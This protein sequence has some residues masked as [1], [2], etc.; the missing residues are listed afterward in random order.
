[1]PC[2]TNMI[3]ELLEYKQNVTNIVLTMPHLTIM[4]LELLEHKQNASLKNTDMAMQRLTIMISEHQKNDISQILRKQLILSSQY[5]Y[6]QTQQYRTN[7]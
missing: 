7:N 1:M 3:L 6:I 2:L 5:L 4:I